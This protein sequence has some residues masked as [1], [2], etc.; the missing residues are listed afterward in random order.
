MSLMKEP[1][2]E[3]ARGGNEGT[4]WICPRRPQNG[5]EEWLGPLGVGGDTR[6]AF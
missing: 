3:V 1:A 2:V 4:G 6:L 5:V